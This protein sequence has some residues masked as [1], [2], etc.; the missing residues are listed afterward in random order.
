VNEEKNH[1]IHLQPKDRWFSISSVTSHTSSELLRIEDAL[2][3]NNE[4]H[5]KTDARK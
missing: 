4:T 1:N 5:P 3:N 2:L